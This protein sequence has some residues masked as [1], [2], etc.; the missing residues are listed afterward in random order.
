ME[1]EAQTSW[2]DQIDTE[3]A[4]AAGAA[5]I[6]PAYQALLDGA[7]KTQVLVT[8]PKPWPP[9]HLTVGFLGTTGRSS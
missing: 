3:D 2:A 9:T 1:P 8:S 5:S 6:G 4:L 7:A